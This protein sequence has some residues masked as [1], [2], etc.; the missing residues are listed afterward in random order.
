M[1]IA[2]I[3]DAEMFPNYR[4]EL[5]DAIQKQG[6]QACVVNAPSPPYRWDDLKRS[7]RDLVPV[8]GCVVAHG[9][10]ELVTRIGREN[11]WTPGVFAT[12]E[13]YYC[14]NYFVHFGDY[15]LNGD[16]L[17]LPF[18]ELRRRREFLMDTLGINGSVFLRPDSPLKL[19]TGQT[20]SRDTFDADVECMGFYDFPQNS[21]VVVS[22]PKAID[23]EWRFVIADRRVV[24]SC[25]YV[26]H[27]QH[28]YSKD[29]PSE[30]FELAETIAANGYQPDPVWIIDI[31]RTSEGD[32]RLLEI[33][34]FS[35]ANLYACDKSSIVAEVSAVAH[36]LW[37]ENSQS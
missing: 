10:I 36:R 26:A 5:I 3:V 6:H 14:S 21:L 7:Y 9:D 20:A 37:S 15:L 34:G 16:Y 1:N 2:W 29:V 13:N 4:D 35:F 23:Y 17:M 8:G 11:Q 22:S 33:G 19:F 24:A 31:C 30:A 18:G 32:Y 27:G 25:Q 28:E 12:V